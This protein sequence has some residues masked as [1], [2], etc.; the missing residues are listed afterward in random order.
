MNAGIN[1]IAFL[2]HSC[3]QEVISQFLEDGKDAFFGGHQSMLSMFNM[4]EPTDLKCVI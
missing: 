4:I 3:L 1:N 2:L